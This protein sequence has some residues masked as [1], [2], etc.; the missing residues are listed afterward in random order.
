M[1]LVEKIDVI[2][3]DGDILTISDENVGDMV[4][5]SVKK[6]IRR[7]AAKE[8]AEMY[9]AEKIAFEVFESANALYLPFGH[10]NETPKSVFGRFLEYGDITH[11]EVYF[12]DGT[13]VLFATD[14]K[15]KTTGG[16][17]N[18]Y[19]KTILAKNGNLYVLIGKDMYTDDYFDIDD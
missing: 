4:I 18:L 6:E 10:V 16:R 2:F 13:S 7:L 5:S 11:I 15:D 3:E 19:Q 14:W 17:E 9:Y 12:D 8:I 1:R